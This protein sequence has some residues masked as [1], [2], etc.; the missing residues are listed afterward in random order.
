[1]QFDVGLF[2]SLTV[3]S[4][5]QR[6]ASPES[7]LP[8]KDPKKTSIEEVERA[9]AV[10]EESSIFVH[11]LLSCFVLRYSECSQLQVMIFDART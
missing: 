4:S 7:T 2:N 11:L 9:R 5:A 3:N 8:A 10:A 1:M 6:L